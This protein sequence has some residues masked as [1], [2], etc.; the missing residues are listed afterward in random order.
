MKSI[1]LKRQQ[2]FV[3]ALTC[4]ALLIAGV[5]CATRAQAAIDFGDP[6]VRSQRGQ[7]LNLVVPYGAAPGQHVSAVRFIVSDIEV[8]PGYKAP[9]IDSLTVLKPLDRNVVYLQ[10]RD[11]FDAPSL[12]LKI[13]V[14]GTDADPTPLAVA[15]PPAKLAELA[16]AVTAAKP[17]APSKRPRK[18]GK[19]KHALAQ[20]VQSAQAP[21]Q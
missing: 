8:P 2:N 14:A 16:H 5:Y 4:G 21:A 7:R 9:S 12:K 3:R 11:R 13:R 10:S 19:T 20:P 1:A 15:V 18:A 17:S 6:S